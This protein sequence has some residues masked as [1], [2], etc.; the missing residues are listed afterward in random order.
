LAITPQNT[1]T[2]CEAWKS[3]GKII[4]HTGLAQDPA[5]SERIYA[6]MIRSSDPEIREA[7]LVYFYELAMQMKSHFSIF[8]DKLV[9]FALNI[10][11]ANNELENV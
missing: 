9:T 2:I 6:E 10:A 11:D 1:A 4:H 5:I 7:G 8:M 3:M